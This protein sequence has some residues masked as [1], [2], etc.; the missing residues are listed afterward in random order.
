MPVTHELQLFQIGGLRRGR[1]SLSNKWTSQ[2]A[3]RVRVRAPMSARES[4]SGTGYCSVILSPAEN[5]SSLKTL[6]Q[7]LR[8]KR[9]SPN[10][11]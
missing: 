3:K 7:G 8:R 9:G 11:T 1:T 4:S 6:S 2:Q 10:G 5:P